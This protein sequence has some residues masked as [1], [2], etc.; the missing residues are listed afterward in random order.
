MIWLVVLAVSILLVGVLLILDGRRQ[1]KELL[2]DWELVLTPRGSEMLQRMA[3]SSSA[4]L[5]LLDMTQEQAREAR[6]SGRDDDAVRMLAA[7]CRLIEAYCPNM[8]HALAAM[9]LLSRMV[10]AMAPVRS[11]RPPSFRVRDLRHLALLDQFL[12]HLLV[13]TAERFRLRLFILSRGFGLLSRFFLRSVARVRAR[14]SPEPAWKDL[15]ATSADLRSLNGEAL[16]AF[17]VLL[18][19]M[20]AVRR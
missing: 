5:D 4:Q 17:K 9:A 18:V 2:R 15:E 20:D 1:E 3:V 12:R 14:Q 8:L 6:D 19:S 7:G 11:L 10:T 16:D 13:S